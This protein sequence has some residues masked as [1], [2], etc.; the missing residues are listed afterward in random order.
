MT[1]NKKNCKGYYKPETIAKFAE[2]MKEAREAV[3]AGDNLTVS[4]SNANSKMGNVTSVSL[5]PFFSCP[6]RCRGTCAVKCYAAKLANLRP[7]VLKSYA[8][9]QAIA[10]YRPDVYWAAVDLAIKSVRYFRFHVS[11]DILNKDYFNRTIEVSRNN[12]K[13]E[14]LMFTKKYEIVNEWIAENGE[15]PENLH[16][17]F[18]AWGEMEPINPYHL[19]ETNIIPKGE[20]DAWWDLPDNKY[21]NTWKICGG[22]CFNCA[23]RGVGCWQAKKEETIAFKLH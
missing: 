15:L 8:R 2:A 22:N 7:S 20:S 5:M 6:G 9:N 1:Q 3:K 12:P 21:G 4:I 23:C 14:I 11:G 16:I 10:M 18:S 17:L 19:P 13:T